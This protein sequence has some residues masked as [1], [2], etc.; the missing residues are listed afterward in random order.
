MRQSQFRVWM[1]L[2]RKCVTLASNRCF[3][4]IRIAFLITFLFSLEMFILLHCMLCLEF[5]QDS[6][7]HNLHK[8][9]S[10]CVYFDVSITLIVVQQYYTFSCWFSPKSPQ[11]YLSLIVYVVLFYIEEDGLI[12]YRWEGRPL[13]LYRFDSSV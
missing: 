13:I 1:T 8:T 3:S 6:Q 11:S 7:K 12:W 5:L 2:Q 9:H 4:C 10:L